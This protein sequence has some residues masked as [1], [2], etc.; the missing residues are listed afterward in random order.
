[1]FRLSNSPRGQEKASKIALSSQLAGS[2][3]PFAEIS[4]VPPPILANITIEGQTRCQTIPING[5]VTSA[6]G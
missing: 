3:A 1:M 2:G 4:P 5:P 6:S